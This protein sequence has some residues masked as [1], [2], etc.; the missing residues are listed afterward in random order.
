MK[1]MKL[2]CTRTT[3]EIQVFKTG[4]WSEWVK[5]KKIFIAIV[6]IIL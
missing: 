4:Y 2:Q 3:R 6:K 1:V 5:E